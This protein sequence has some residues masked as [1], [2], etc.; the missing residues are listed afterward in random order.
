MRNKREILRRVVTTL[1]VASTFFAS[2]AQDRKKSWTFD[3][4]KPGVIPAEFTNEVG[5]WKIVAVETAPSKPN[6]LA[7]LAKNERP[8]FNIAL[9][10][11]TSYTNLDITV[12]IR[13]IA[14]QIDQGG[15]VVWRARDA[16]NYYI[17]RYNPLEDNYRVYK[18][19]DGGRIQL[20]TADVKRSEGWHTL[21]VTMVG[22]RIECY[23]DSK[24]YLEVSDST[25]KEAGKIGLWTKA[26]A[27]TH[28]DD[29][30]VSSN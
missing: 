21:R 22:E 26:D 14:G 2:A 17:A 11:G 8:V 4:E 3:A 30:T 15:G 6:V 16:K 1:L 20:G 25:F 19:E 18:V 24:K 28:F 5:E 27:Q 29:L 10:S 9:A 7:Q 13:S 23:Y 12:K